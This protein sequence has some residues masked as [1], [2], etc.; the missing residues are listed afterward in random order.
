MSAADSTA[1]LAFMPPA[2]PGWALPRGPVTSDV[3]AAFLAG[4]ALNSLDNLVCTATPWAGA[5]RQRMA[6]KCAAA[7]VALAGRTEDEAQLRDA[8]HLR[9]AGADPGPAG[10]LLAAWRRLAERSPDIGPDALRSIVAVLGLRWRDD[11][12]GLECFDGLA[13]SNRPAPLVAA[14]LMAEVQRVRP[15]AELLAWWLADLAIAARMRWPMAMPMLV[16]QAR[17]PAFR[18]AGGRGRIRPGGEGFERGICVALALAAAQACRLAGEI[19]PRAAR[20][21]AAAPKLR[22]KGA[23]D[24]IQLLLDDDAV[25]GTW[26]T[27]SLTRWGARRLFDRLTSLDAV[28]ELSG[29]A[30]FRLYGL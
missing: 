5:W 20:L 25:S 1:S 17:G 14:A 30:S 15:D 4:A 7:A 11:L 6:L 26:Q 8:W 18:S 2:V 3:E 27:A 28:R 10:N 9:T 16:T 13:R 23:G 22:A 21:V 29:R 19:A 12:A 24:V